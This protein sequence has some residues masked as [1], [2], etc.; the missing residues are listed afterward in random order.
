MLEIGPCREGKVRS[1]AA[2]SDC[3]GLVETAFRDTPYCVGLRDYGCDLGTDSVSRP[4]FGGFRR[5]AT[6]RFSDNSRP[7]SRGSMSP[8]LADR[9]R[10][11]YVATCAGRPTTGCHL[12]A[13]GTRRGMAC[14]P[15]VQASV[16]I[17]PRF[18]PIA[19]RACASLSRTI[20]GF[21][22]IETSLPLERAIL[23]GAIDA[24]RHF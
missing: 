18:S 3:S 17:R 16:L 14:T 11:I 12:D 4:P 15:T 8:H 2:A 22:R 9:Y 6:G 7:R 13:V 1:T 19:P 21:A 24:D 23:G 10:R 20:V 5:T